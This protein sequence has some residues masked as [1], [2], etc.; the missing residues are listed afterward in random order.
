VRLA[1]HLLGFKAEELED[2]RVA[3]GQARLQGLG[4]GPGEFRQFRLVVGEAG[5]LEVQGGDLPLQLPHRPVAADAL[6]LVEGA[7]ARVRNRQEFGDVGEGQPGDEFPARDAQFGSRRL[8]DRGRGLACGDAEMLRQFGRHRLPNLRISLVELPIASQLPLL[9][10]ADAESLQSI[11][12]ILQQ[13]RA[14]SGPVRAALFVFGH[15]AADEPIAER[16]ADID[17]TSGL[18]GEFLVNATNRKDEIL[19]GQP[20]DLG[21]CAFLRLA[22]KR[23]YPCTG[24]GS[25]GRVAPWQGP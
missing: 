11:G 19:E 7:L 12:E 1:H 2:I 13:F 6:E 3:N 22:H 18:G 16:E 9:G 23:N 25:A 8:P 15:V 14:V 20:G 4:T 24:R 10:P 21:H 17:G 5:A